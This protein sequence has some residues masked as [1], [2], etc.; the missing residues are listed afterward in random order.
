MRGGRG[1]YFL[2]YVP[3]EAQAQALLVRCAARLTAS[4]RRT[5]RRFVASARSP[6]AFAWLA[7]RPLRA[8]AGRNETLGS[9]TELVRGILWR[10][11]ADYAARGLRAPGRRPTD[12]RFPDDTSFAQQRLRRWRA[13]A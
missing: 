9:E 6:A 13:R 2:G 11:F 10:W 12:A 1:A 4:K 3:R 5:L 8:L 7:V